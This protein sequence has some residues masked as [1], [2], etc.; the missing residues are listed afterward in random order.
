MSMFRTGL[1]LMLLAAL[2]LPLEAQQFSGTLRGI[3]LDSTGAI[4]QGAEVSIVEVA[5]NDTHVS[6]VSGQANGPRQ[7]QVATKL[8][9]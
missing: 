1:T 2:C 4:V 7:I 5:T 6:V 9:F 3:V 8:I